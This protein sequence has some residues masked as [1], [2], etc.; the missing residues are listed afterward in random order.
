MTKTR[1]LVGLTAVVVLALVA[2]LFGFGRGRACNSLGC[3]DG[4]NYSIPDDAYVAWGAERRVPV[5]VETCIDDVCQTSDVT[6]NRGGKVRSGGAQV[7]LDAGTLDPGDVY[8]MALKV[9]DPSGMVRYARTDSGATLSRWQPNGPD[10]EPTC[11]RWL[12][13]IEPEDLGL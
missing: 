8:T 3:N 9:T 2:A 10:C 1:L 11:A 4:V 6:V 5:V 13:A 12:L 7:S